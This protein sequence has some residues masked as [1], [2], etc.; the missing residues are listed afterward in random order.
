L[1]LSSSTTTPKPISLSSSPP[2]PVAILLC[3]DLLQQVIV[4]KM[5]QTL[6][7]LLNPIDYCYHQY[8]HRSKEGTNLSLCLFVSIYLFLFRRG[9]LVLCMWVQSLESSFRAFGMR[10]REQLL[11]SLP[12]NL[13]FFLSFFACLSF[14]N[15]SRTRYLLVQGTS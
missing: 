7:L 13:T 8:S 4:A 11:S 10:E 15:G 2:P 14:S 3:K 6:H 12:D 5:L 1:L 9:F